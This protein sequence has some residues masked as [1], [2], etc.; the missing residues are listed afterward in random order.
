MVAVGLASF[1]VGDRSIYSS[2]L[3]TR[4]DSPAHRYRFAMPL[5]GAVAVGGATRQARLVLGADDT[6][7]TARARMGAIDV[8][9][10]PVV[11]RDGAVMGVIDLASLHALADEQR[12]PASAIVRE[13]I[14]AADDGL[15]DAL[16]A[17]ADHGRT[18]APVVTDGRLAGVLSIRDAMTAYRT[19]LNGNIRQVRGLR[20]GGVIIET[21]I[22]KGSALAGRLVS[23]VEW[24]REA[25]LVAIERKETLMV[26]RGDLRLLPGD[27]L[28]IFATPM[29]QPRVEDLLDTP[30]ATEPVLTD[31][32]KKAPS[33]P[34]DSRVP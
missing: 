12:I 21:Q 15:D 5:L 14:L 30:V 6:V 34:G 22:D 2:Q 18:W 7:A 3:A 28:S 11:S 29:A 24:P 9:G 32:D 33:A 10:A 4:A 27:H 26:P 25:V 19:A 17:L 20:T 31:S 23:E 1:V 16:G 8:P 13:P